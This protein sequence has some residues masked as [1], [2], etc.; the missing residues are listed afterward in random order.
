ML[1]RQ[2]LLMSLKVQWRWQMTL[3]ESIQSQQEHCVQ[4]ETSQMEQNTSHRTI[5]NTATATVCLQQPLRSLPTTE[6]SATI[7]RSATTAPHRNRK[8]ANEAQPLNDERQQRQT[9]C[10]QQ[11]LATTPRRD[12]KLA[13]E[14]TATT[15]LDQCNSLL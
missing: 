10:S 7:A 1:H 9:V 14:R 13:N 5:S 4:N 8:L 15:A 2:W 12:R 6:R 3:K 11:P